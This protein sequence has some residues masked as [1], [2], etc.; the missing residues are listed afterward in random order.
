MK[1]EELLEFPCGSGVMNLA[2]THEDMGV[3]PGPHQW[4][5]DPAFRE[6]WCRLQTR[7]GSGMAVVVV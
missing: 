7:L 2:S 4:V 6:L 3:I 1:D 5:K